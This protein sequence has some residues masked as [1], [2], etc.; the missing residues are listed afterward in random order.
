MPCELCDHL[1]TMTINQ[2]AKPKKPTKELSTLGTSNST[3]SSAS[4]DMAPSTSGDSMAIVP[5]TISAEALT[6]VGSGTFGGTTINAPLTSSSE[7]PPSDYQFSNLL[8]HLALDRVCTSVPRVSFT[9]YVDPSALETT[10]DLGLSLICP[11]MTTTAYS[12]FQGYF[13]PYQV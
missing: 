3:A 8:A 2:I 5:S 10:P 12:M 1:S 7:D 13:G 11:T 6:V 4:Q 9:H